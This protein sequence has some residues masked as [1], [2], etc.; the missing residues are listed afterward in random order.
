MVKDNIIS[1]VEI[2]QLRP[3]TFDEFHQHFVT[4][5]K[6]TYTQMKIPRALKRVDDVTFFLERAF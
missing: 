3:G 5:P 4:D 1:G 6:V 2:V